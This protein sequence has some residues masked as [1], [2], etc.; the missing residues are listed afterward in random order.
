MDIILKLSCMSTSNIKWSCLYSGFGIL[1]ILTD[2]DIKKLTYKLKCGEHIREQLKDMVFLK[3]LYKKGKPVFAAPPTEIINP[4]KYM[5]DFSSFNKIISPSSQSIGILALLRCAEV[6]YKSDKVLSGIMVNAAEI[7]YEFLTTYLRNE[8]G[9]FVTVE[10]RTKYINDELKIKIIQK[11]AKLLDQIYV[12]EAF[13]YLYN[14]TS[15]IEAKEFYNSKNIRYYNE[16]KSMFNYIFENYNLLLE[17]STKE[18]C[19]TISSLARCCRINHDTQQI[20]NYQHLI[21]LLCAELE[22]R[23]KINGEIEKNLEDSAPASI[24]THFRA[25]SALLEGYME[26]NIEKFKELAYSIY[27]YL[28]DLYD[29]TLGLYLQGDYSKIKYSIRDIADII[30]SSINYYKVFGDEN[31][32]KTIKEFYLSSME[33]S[34]IVQEIEK[35]NSTPLGSEIN[36]P[37]CIPDSNDIERAPVFLKSFRINFKKTATINISKYFNSLYSLYASYTF[38]NQMDVEYMKNDT[39]ESLEDGF[40]GLIKL[41]DTNDMPFSNEDFKDDISL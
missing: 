21:A 18:I 37:E 5:W 20:I 1:H 12:H 10:N 8:S 14:L 19:Y 9:L 34:G 27:S 2:K 30:N 15:K 23:L 22:S 31:V 29:P 26:T 16:S 25:V 13:N 32:I 35:T 24:T 11:D 7:Y 3:C 4:G 40:N 41:Y 28:T 38:L 33:N 39:L 6:N 36:L 17:H